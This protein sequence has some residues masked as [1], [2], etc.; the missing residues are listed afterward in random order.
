MFN[1]STWGN[2]PSRAPDEMQTKISQGSE[3]K[4]TSATTIDD[5]GEREAG[6]LLLRMQ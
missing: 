5:H 3:H 6:L 2:V 1:G 4:P